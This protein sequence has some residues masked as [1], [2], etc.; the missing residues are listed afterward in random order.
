MMA[1]LQTRI[2]V[3]KQETMTLCG[4]WGQES[5]VAMWQDFG[6]G[7]SNTGSSASQ[8]IDSTVHCVISP[9]VSHYNPRVHHK[10]TSLKMTF[11]CVKSGSW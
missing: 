1:C 11:V 8:L 4:G 6:L 3:F 2:P 10:C 5:V 9:S 7:P